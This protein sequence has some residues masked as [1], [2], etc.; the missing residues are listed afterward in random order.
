M[1]QALDWGLFFRSGLI[2]STKPGYLVLSW[3]QV[4]ESLFPFKETA[5]WSFFCPDFYFKNPRY[6]QFEY[7][8]ECSHAELLDYLTTSLESLDT[9]FS[10]NFSELNFPL[11]KSK[12]NQ[13]QEGIDSG[14]I[15][16]AVP[17]IP[18][19]SKQLFSLIE[20]KHLLK[21]LL[22]KINI[23]LNQ[24]LHIYGL[25]LKSDGIL[26]ASPEILFSYSTTSKA[27]KSMALA[28][29]DLATSSKGSLLN[30]TKEK[31]EHDIVSQCL[32]AIFLQLGKPLTKNPT[33]EWDIGYLK[34]LRKDFQI[35]ISDFN[36]K[37]IIKLLHPTPALGT[38]PQ[39]K[40]DFLKDLDGPVNRLQ[41]GAPF[42][43]LSPTG[44]VKAI[45]AIRNIQWTS[46]YLWLFVGCGII[47]K[48]NLQKEFQE[49]KN[50]AKSIKILLGL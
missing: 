39:N 35:N 28:G 8:I 6:L 21:S 14:E 42:V 23:E 31:H 9:G 24:A 15:Q 20:K 32:E 12:F 41:Y 13:I 7:N 33:Y 46:T 44:N 38:S 34:H 10:Q 17:V 50:K 26:G 4:T 16:K 25:F 40:W 11:F 22:E 1:F 18:Q 29:T 30:S 3:G 48:S 47:A 19:Q 37:K 45:V 2:F 5:T 27:L 49:L 43:S 36:F